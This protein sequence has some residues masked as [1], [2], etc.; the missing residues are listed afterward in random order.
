MSH[1]LSGV[2]VWTVGHSTRAAAELVELLQAHRI[3]VLIDVRKIPRSRR[4]P[5]FNL[6]A[7]RAILE[8]SGT[9]YRHEPGLGGLRRPRKDSINTAWQNPGFRGYA[10]YMQTDEFR[11]SVD[12]LIAT[13]RRARVALMCAEAVPWR[14][15]RSL[16][17][18]ALAA[19]GATVHHILSPTRAEAHRVTPFALV[20]GE[21]VTY[22]GLAPI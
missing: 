9:V 6:D 15:H 12:G 4:N 7:L 22:P 14:C 2:E 1:S 10:D 16:I 18:D 20:T 13:A 5:Q 21:E 8:E 19:R 3:E 11:R 17:A